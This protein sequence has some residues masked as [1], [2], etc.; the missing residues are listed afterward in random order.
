MQLLPQSANVDVNGALFDKNMIAPDF[1]K[2]LGTAVDPIGVSHEEMQHAKLG[3]PEIDLAPAASNSVC[4]RIKLQARDFDDLVAGKGRAPAYHRLDS[5][6]QLARG[7]GLGD[8]IVRP[9]F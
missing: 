1:I 3:G 8:V 5:R 4:G 2:K 7:E 9:G 6:E